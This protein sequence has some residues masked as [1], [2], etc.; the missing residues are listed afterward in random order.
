[1]E[2]KTR[3]NKRSL[4]GKWESYAASK[5]TEAGLYVIC[6]NFRCRIGE[7]DIIARDGDYLVFVEVKC[8]RSKR[9][10]NPLEAVTLY[11][12]NR[13]RRVAEFFLISNDIRSDTP[14]RFDV[15]GIET[16]ITSE[17]ITECWIKNAF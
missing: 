15:F 9:S 7:I 14:C 5:L 12:Q 2:E 17:K 16:D 3:M 13:I 6:K 11:K 1:M 8:R 10:G 4:G